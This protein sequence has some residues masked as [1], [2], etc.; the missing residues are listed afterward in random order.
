MLVG[1][2]ALGIDLA[3]PAGAAPQHEGD[4]TP[5]TDRPAV[6][7]D[8]LYAA[9]AAEDASSADSSVVEVIAPSSSTDGHISWYGPGFNGRRTANGEKFDMYELTAAHKRLPFNTI[10]RVVDNRSG[11]A[12][13]V[14]INDRGPFIRGR[15]LD[16]SKKAATDLGMIGR[17]TTSGTLE[18]YEESTRVDE[19]TPVSN[20][21]AK[22]IR[23]ITFD[24]DARGVKPSGTSVRL[25][26]VETL[27]E[28]VATMS[29][30][31]ATYPTV[32]IT[33]I[34]SS[35]GTEWQVCVGLYANDHLAND[36]LIEVK[37][38]YPNAALVSFEAGFPATWTDGS[39]VAAAADRLDST[40]M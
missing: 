14:R 20:G 36:L 17:G 13:L 7:L 37:E 8:S 9:K 15:V 39:S 12:I 1:A 28:A 34:S 2:V 6:N 23:Y 18:V 5:L 40:R 11:K 38:S 29:T 35:N 24:V 19:A 16:L 33:R 26:S 31:R 3:R 4:N 32:Y 30:L 10:V 27:D 22:S 25:T 21:T